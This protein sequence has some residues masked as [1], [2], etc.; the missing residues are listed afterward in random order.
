VQRALES[1]EILLVAPQ[2]EGLHWVSTSAPLAH[3]RPESLLLLPLMVNQKATGLALLA[4][5]RPI[6]STPQRTLLDAL[7]T[8]AAPHLQNATLHEKI[9]KL[10]AIDDTT[11]VL[12]RRFGTKRLAEEFSRSVRH[13]VPLSV[14]LMDIDHFK[15]FNDTHGHDAGDR[16]LQMVA[17]TVEEMLRAGDVVCRYGGEEFLVVVPG[18]GVN[19]AAALGER[20]RRKI[21]TTAV[22]WGEQSLQVTISLGQATWPVARAAVPEELITAAD[23]A[24]YKAKQAGRD[25]LMIQLADRVVTPQALRAATTNR[26]A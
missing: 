10:A 25:C 4:S 2:R 9:K 1:G 11:G 16:V 14:L 15:R 19:D 21:A 23:A 20:L 26:A 13:G 22:S 24:L 3:F 18:T 12:N 6:L 17:R 5:P 8:H 7:R